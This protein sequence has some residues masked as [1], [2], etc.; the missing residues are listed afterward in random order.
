MPTEFHRAIELN[1]DTDLRS[2]YERTKDDILKGQVSPIY[3]YVAID[4]TH[5][6]L[7]RLQQPDHPYESLEAYRK[8]EVQLVKDGL[9][10]A[11]VIVCVNTPFSDALHTVIGSLSAR[12]WLPAKQTVFGKL[13]IPTI[14]PNFSPDQIEALLGTVY[15]QY[16][17]LQ[18]PP[19]VVLPYHQITENTYMLLM[20]ARKYGFKAIVDLDFHTSPSQQ[21]K[22]AKVMAEDTGLITH[23]IEVGTKPITPNQLK[24]LEKNVGD[25]SP[26]VSNKVKSEIA[27]ICAI[28]GSFL[29]QVP[30]PY[31]IAEYFVSDLFQFKGVCVRDNGEY[32]LHN[33]AIEDWYRVTLDMLRRP[34]GSIIKSAD[35]L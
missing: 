16:M 8:R 26:L 29:G 12:N 24:E 30:L 1:K 32:T 4:H 15:E 11:D 5:N 6:F 19:V 18:I 9:L 3:D 35:V 17:K 14:N 22:Q 34:N 7:T 33:T 13:P 10:T 27:Q 20:N 21:L 23:A 28:V 25:N 2:M 31:Q